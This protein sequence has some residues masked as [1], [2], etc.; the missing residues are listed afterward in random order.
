MKKFQ[1]RSVPIL[2]LAKINWQIVKWVSYP[3]T[4]KQNRM[5]PEA[6]SPSAM[7]ELSEQKNWVNSSVWIF[8]GSGDL[9]LVI[10]GVYSEQFS[11]SESSVVSS[12][13]LLLSSDELTAAS[14]I[15]ITAM[16]FFTPFATCHRPSLIYGMARKQLPQVTDG[17]IHNWLIFTLFSWLLFPAFCLS[18]IFVLRAAL[19]EEKNKIIF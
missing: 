11:V 3:R 4:K 1:G 10:A 18:P 15:F 17:I 16:A 8:P 19:S 2:E 12:S 14:S 7:I 9:T 6:D 13:P 5:N